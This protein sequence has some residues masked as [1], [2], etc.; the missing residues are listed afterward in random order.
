MINFFGVLFAIY[1]VI[2]VAISLGLMEDDGW[3]FMTWKERF[4][5][6]LIDGFGWLF[7]IIWALFR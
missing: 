7:V 4:M 1:L 3:Q 5:A 2:G 6:L